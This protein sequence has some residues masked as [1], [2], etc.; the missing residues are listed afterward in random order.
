MI[1]TIARVLVDVSGNAF[2]SVL[3][4][5]IRR[6]QVATKILRASDGAQI[7]PAAEDGNLATLTGKDFATQTT[8]AAIKAK[9]D[10]IPSDPSREGGKLTALEALITA[11]KDT[12]GIK[13]IVESLPAGDDILG[14]LKLIDRDGAHIARV[15]EDGRLTVA[16]HAEPPT[17]STAVKVLA[18]G[19]VTHNDTVETTYTITNAKTL[20]LQRF[21]GGGENTTAGGRI[22]VVYRP[23]GLPASDVLLAVGYIAGG[24]FQ[25]DL[26]DSFVGDGTKKIV[27]QRINLGGTS[28]RQTG[29]WMGYEL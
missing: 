21:W 27:L 5:A 16:L 20:R 10:N 2:S 25:V 7:N 13:K 14:K 23:T 22:T 6:L 19:Q 4:G 8:L 17:A 12:D 18:D 11:I 3:D 29:C 9:T 15:L 26:D 1:D 28:M 24:N